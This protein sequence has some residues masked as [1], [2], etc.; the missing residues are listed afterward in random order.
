[1]DVRLHNGLTP[2]FESADTMIDSYLMLAPSGNIYQNTHVAAPE[3]PL[4]SVQPQDLPRI[5]NVE[6]Y[7]ARGGIYEY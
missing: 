4:A 5:L 2:V 1:M 7:S 3:I 6:K